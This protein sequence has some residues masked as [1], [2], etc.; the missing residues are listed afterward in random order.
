MTLPPLVSTASAIIAGGL[1]VALAALLWVDQR[2]HQRARIRHR[3]AWASGD[4]ADQAQGTALSVSSQ[5]HSAFA[6]TVRVANSLRF[7]GSGRRDQTQALLESAGFR[8]R[9]G[10]SNYF[11]VKLIASA[12]GAVGAILGV[13]Q[14]VF[15][16]NS[17]MQAALVLAGF[18]LGGLTPELVVR[19]IARRRQTAIRANLPD[20][21][22]LLIIATNAGQ[23]LEVALA[24]VGA[25][26]GRTAPVLADELQVT[27]S[28][29][30]ALPNR[31]QALENFATRTGVAEARSLTATLIQTVRYGTPLTQSL[32]VLAAEQRIARVLTLE[33]KAAKLPAILSLPL[34]LLIMPS[35]FIVTAGPALLSVGDALFGT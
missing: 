33:E 22:D 20:A 25:E 12:C 6:A 7:L 15:A 9:T 31:R 1:F 11:G 16:D 19:R 3:F 29:L 30:R 23:S 34:M 27:T 2:M 32:K 24:R 17:G 4:S 26:L 5:V 21:I 8:G 13:S 14:G 10:V 35:I 28:E 18:F